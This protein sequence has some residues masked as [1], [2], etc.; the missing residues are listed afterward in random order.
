MLTVIHHEI[1]M[2]AYLLLLG[3]KK[4]SCRSEDL[5]SRS[6]STVLNSQKINIIK[7]NGLKVH[8]N[9]ND[10]IINLKYSHAFVFDQNYRLLSRELECGIL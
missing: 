2:L 9:G 10:V 1:L 7:A 6:K 3:S 5:K 8:G 4:S